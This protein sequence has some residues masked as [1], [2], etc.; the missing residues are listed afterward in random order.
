MAEELLDIVERSF[1][2]LLSEKNFQVYENVD[3]QDY[4]SARVVLE[5]LDFRLMFYGVLESHDFRLDRLRDRGMGVAIASWWRDAWADV[6]LLKYLVCGGDLRQRLSL[7]EV[8]SFVRDNYS[9]IKSMF[10]YDNVG[11]T[12]RQLRKLEKERRLQVFPHAFG[13]RKRSRK[14]RSL[15]HRAWSALLKAWPW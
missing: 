12:L 1:S 14:K 11:E 15:L 8:A 3:R 5:S 7:D 4:H 6:T 10:S 9:V 2:F 13:K